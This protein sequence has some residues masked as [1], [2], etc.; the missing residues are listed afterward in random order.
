MKRS[1]RK[2]SLTTHLTVSVGW[3]GA[4]LA[5]VA[6]AIAGVSSGN[7]QLV[8]AA[9]LSMEVIGWYVIVSCSVGALATG[10]VHSLGTEWG[11]LRHYWVLAKFVLTLVATL[12]LVSHMP[13]VSRM[14]EH[15]ASTPA[16]STD[17]A[18]LQM[19]LLV[20]AVGGLLVLLVV[21]TLSVFKPW[22]RTGYGRRK[23]VET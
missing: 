17:F 4:V 1:L 6:L 22:G 21:V 5:Y 8:R 3:L 19:Q 16:L 9:Y 2:L 23:L 10:L 18:R 15:A 7:A 20:H 12:V 13:T 14:A 11:L